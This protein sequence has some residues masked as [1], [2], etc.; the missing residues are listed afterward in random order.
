[1]NLFFDTSAL[2][3]FFHD[4]IGTERVTKWIMASEYVIWISELARLEMIS[5]LYRR[6]RNNEISSEKLITATD[7]FEEQ[8]ESFQVEPLSQSIVLESER[9]LKV[10]GKNQGLRTLDALHLGT[11]SLICD[12][13]W[14]FV[15]S[16]DN[17][18]KVVTEMGYS[19]MNP[20][21][22]R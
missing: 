18:C 5:A 16:D 7:A 3:K 12:E 2:V 4:E 22:E 6:Y 21:D 14:S 1:M 17:L 9:L 19:V 20:V 13:Y 15:A 10:Y 8:I 11:Y